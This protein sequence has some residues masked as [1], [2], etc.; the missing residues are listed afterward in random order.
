MGYS[1]GNGLQP[2]GG[3][4]LDVIERRDAIPNPMARTQGPTDSRGSCDARCTAPISV[5]RG[6]RHRDATEQRR[7]SHRVGCPSNMDVRP[8]IV[9]RLS[10]CASQ[11]DRVEGDVDRQHADVSQVP[12]QDAEMS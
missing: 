4:A 5:N 11:A 1:P 10:K 2:E 3:S 8:S 9:G 7:L 6:M 12:S